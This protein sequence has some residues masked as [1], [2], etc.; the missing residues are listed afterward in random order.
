MHDPV[1]EWRQEGRLCVWRYADPGRGWGGWHLTGDPA[2]CRSVRNLLD[3]LHGGP[4]RYRTL[5]LEPVTEAVLSVPNYSKKHDGSFAKLRLV[6]EPE[7]EDLDL[8]IEGDVLIMTVGS[9]RLRKLAAALTEVEVGGGD[10]G[11]VT[12][13]R[14]KAQGWM[15]WWMPDVKYNWG[16][17]K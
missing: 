10:F 1:D 13:D 9:K 16:M 5:R 2:G 4:G 6:Y 12:S 8:S 14:R 11:I 17:R 3:R 7:G 15:F